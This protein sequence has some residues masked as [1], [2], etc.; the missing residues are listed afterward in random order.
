MEMTK[1]VC[2]RESAG[3]SSSDSKEKLQNTPG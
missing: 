3:E 1:A 2:K